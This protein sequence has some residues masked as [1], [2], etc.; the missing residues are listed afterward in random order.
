VRRVVAALVVGWVILAMGTGTARGAESQECPA[1][2]T[3]ESAEVSVSLEIRGRRFDQWLAT[4]TTRVDV[5][6]RWR[7]AE[8]LLWDDEEQQYLT[9]MRC[10]LGTYGADEQHRRPTVV[11]DGDS[12]IVTDVVRMTITDTRSRL[13]LWEVNLGVSPWQFT[14]KPDLDSDGEPDVLQ[15]ARWASV[16]VASGVPVSMV[17]SNPPPRR[18]RSGKLT[19]AGLDAPWPPPWVVVWLKPPRPMAVAAWVNTSQNWLVELVNTDQEWLAGLVETDQNWL[20]SI[21]A[22]GVA[23]LL[24]YVPAV[25]IALLLRHRAGRRSR[26]GRAATWLL[27]TIVALAVTHGLILVA[28][29]IT[30]AGWFIDEDVGDARAVWESVGW[31]MLLIAVAVLAWWHM[32]RTRPHR[33]AAVGA[34]L[35]IGSLTWMAG[36]WIVR[37]E[38][39]RPEMEGSWRPLIT[40]PF[41]ADVLPILVGIVAGFLLT[42]A[43]AAAAVRVWRTAEWEPTMRVRVV[44]LVLVAV[45]MLLAVL[46]PVQYTAYYFA[47]D[48]VVRWLSEGEGLWEEASHYPRWMMDYAAWPLWILVALAVLAVLYQRPT[49]G[50]RIRGT[51]RWLAV[52]FFVLV[53]VEWPAWYAGVYFPLAAVLTYGAMLTYL[54]LTQARTLSARISHNLGARAVGA[55]NAQM[56]LVNQARRYNDLEAEGKRLESRWSSGDA[57][58]APESYAKERSQLR[59]R[60]MQSKTAAGLGL[61]TKLTP[62][63]AYLAHG[64]EDTPWRNGIAAAERAL[65]PA[66]LAT[67]YIL[68]DRWRNGVWHTT[69]DGWFG[70]ADLLLQAVGEFLFWIGIAFMLGY[71]WRE[72]PGAR[73]YIKPWPLIAAYAIGAVGHNILLHYYHQSPPQD[74]LTRILLMF[75]F[76]TVVAV[77]MDLRA[78]DAL[79]EAWSARLAPLVATYRVGAATTTLAFLLAQAAAAFAL[80]QQLRM[81]T[82]ITPPSPSPPGTGSR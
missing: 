53:A 39:D 62:V 8:H 14:L 23:D 73:G 64:P 57:E 55:R 61:N 30:A 45:A 7:L 9:A 69:L 32:L 52:F 4:S 26:L 36:V 80:W 46:S 29:M 74:Q 15:E 65:I 67:C 20:V 82:G 42:A 68:F 25:I 66:V 81:G 47:R 56:I 27:W 70:P 58:L 5:P 48:E 59:A 22:Y 44:G 2:K 63:D 71:L 78:L 33:W 24:V 50:F 49:P 13:A 40:E 41:S 37:A 3:L 18:N 72:L 31:V 34:A 77:L 79:R 6:R 17:R 11:A 10:L 54:A 38:A 51:N 19:W 76:L 16:T 75:V 28:S 1:P 43:F 21:A 35:A 60:I 12:V